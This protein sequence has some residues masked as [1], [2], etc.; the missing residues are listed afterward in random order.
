MFKGRSG[1]IK[2]SVITTLLLQIITLICGLIVPRL[3]L[4]A[5]GSEAYGA[6]TSISQFLSHNSQFRKLIGLIKIYVI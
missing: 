4:G 6:T 5:Y 1:R 2:K 3:L